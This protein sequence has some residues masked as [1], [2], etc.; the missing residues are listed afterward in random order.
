MHT[1]VCVQ[2]RL[3]AAERAEQERLQE[4]SRQMAAQM[5]VI[6]ERGIRG[7]A[8]GKGEADKEDK[9]FIAPEEGEGAEGA[10]AGET[11]ETAEAEREEQVEQEMAKEM[12]Q[13]EEGGHEEEPQDE[14]QDEAQEVSL[15]EC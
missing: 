14:A 10:E 4:L 11:G 15:R 7:A 3:A 6:R 9:D 8:S 5:A 2:D 13:E 12:E 1:S